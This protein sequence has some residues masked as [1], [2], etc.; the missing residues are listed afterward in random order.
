[1][2]L[3]RPGDAPPDDRALVE[4]LKA[5][6][7]E[8]AGE[9][10]D[11]YGRLVNTV[12]YRILGGGSEHDDRVQETFIEA[13]RSIRSLRD[14]GA[15][16]AWMTTLAARVA[17]AEL[18]RRKVRRFLSLAE[19]ELPDVASY[20]DHA[21]RDALVATFKI[22]D[23]MPIDERLAFTLRFV[24]GEELVVVAEA[25][26]CSLATVKRWLA[27]AEARFVAQCQ[28]HPELARRLQEGGRWSAQ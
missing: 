20:D 14:D 11:R 9:L 26:G 22:L 17:R 10:F 21:A 3:V 7:A 1:L 15:L 18:R 27:R 2:V 12:L 19:E 28:K 6:N 24:H 13:V 16:R 8:A 25:C 5:G 23:A 4:R